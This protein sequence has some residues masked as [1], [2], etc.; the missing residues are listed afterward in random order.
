MNQPGEPSRMVPGLCH[1]VSGN[2]QCAV[3]EIIDIAIVLF[4]QPDPVIRGHGTPVPIL[5]G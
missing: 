3:P 4:Y 2:I 1:Q 5:H